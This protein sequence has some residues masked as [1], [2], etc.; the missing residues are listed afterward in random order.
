MFKCQ[1][2]FDT[3]IIHVFNICKPCRIWNIC[4]ERPEMKLQCQSSILVLTKLLSFNR[5][6]TCNKCDKTVENQVERYINYCV[7]NNKIRDDLW[8]LIIKHIGYKGFLKFILKPS[9]MQICD[10]IA[11][12]GHYVTND[13]EGLLVMLINCIH[14]M[15]T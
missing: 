1:F 13:G 10:I 14:K 8:S 11:G 2:A 6:E 15:V 5:P 12:L 4:R 9:K 7:K 3:Q